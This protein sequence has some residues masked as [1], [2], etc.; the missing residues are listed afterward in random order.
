[1]N[2]LNFTQDGRRWVSDAFRPSESNVEVKIGFKNEGGG[3]IGVHRSMD[4]VEFTPF[5]GGV[6][7][8]LGKDTRLLIFNISGM[9]PGS[10][11]RLVSTTEA[12]DCGWSE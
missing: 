4:G 6:R 2:T 7:G 1:M 5:E 11:L 9:L 3:F 8:N 10:Y 12:E